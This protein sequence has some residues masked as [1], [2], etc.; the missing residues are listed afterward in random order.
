MSISGR[1]PSIAVLREF[2]NKLLDEFE[3]PSTSGSQPGADLIQPSSSRRLEKQGM[4][5]DAGCVICVSYKPRCAHFIG[6]V[7]QT[8]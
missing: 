1:T 5:I 6:R 3:H 2:V 4:S 8:R 7:I